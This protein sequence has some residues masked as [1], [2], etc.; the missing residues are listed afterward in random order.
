MT[1][2]IILAL[3][4]AAMPVF[5]GA[6]GSEGGGGGCGGGGGDGHE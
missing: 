3:A 6:E 2:H 1:N 5:K 4:V